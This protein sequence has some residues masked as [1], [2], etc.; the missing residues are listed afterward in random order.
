MNSQGKDRSA[1]RPAAGSNLGSAVSNAES[2]TPQRFEKGLLDSLDKTFLRIL[3]VSV[4]AHISLIGYFL[5]NPL[6]EETTQKSI[7]SVQKQLAKSLKERALQQQYVQFHLKKKKPV[8]VAGNTGG[9]RAVKKPKK[10]VR[11]AKVVKKKPTTTVAKNKAGGRRG[12]TR[13]RKKRVSRSR[14]AANVSKKGVLAVL[15]SSSNAA[16]GESVADLIGGSAQVAGDLDKAMSGISNLSSGRS[17]SGRGTAGVRGGR[18]GKG[19]DIDGVVS[20]LGGTSSESFDRSGELVV[21]TSSPLIEDGDG[22]GGA[23]GRGQDDIQ[24]VILKHNKSVQYCYERQLKRNPGLRG[25][26][27]V[28]FT[29]TVQGTVENVELVTST[30]GNKSVERCVINRIRRWN[31]FGEVD[32]SYGPTTIRQSYA[33]GY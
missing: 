1:G 16:V 29:V 14:I 25:K 21:A 13:A 11:T 27:T 5:L 31:D 17:K 7:S 8:A 33:F 28:R 22:N 12:R 2:Q 30:L 6:P 19:A 10:P 20:E 18:S 23:V 26:I 15:T 4:I 9:K 24:V 3:L 32:P